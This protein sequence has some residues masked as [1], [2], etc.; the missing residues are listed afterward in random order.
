MYIWQFYRIDVI[1][2]LAAE[3]ED[4]FEEPRQSIFLEDSIHKAHVAPVLSSAP[5]AGAS[6]DEDCPPPPPRKESLQQPAPQV[7]VRY[8]LVSLF[9]LFLKNFVMI[10]YPP[11]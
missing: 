1:L 3:F 11:E 8:A 7:K 5:T 2:T 4:I 6:N 9:L 10:V